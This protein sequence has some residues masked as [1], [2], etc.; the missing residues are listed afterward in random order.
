[1]NELGRNRYIYFKVEEP[2][3]IDSFQIRS[4]Y[5]D[6][7]DFFRGLGIIGYA[8]TFK[9]WLRKFP[10]PIFIVTVNERE[11]ISWAFVEEWGDYARDGTSVYVLR[12]IETLPKLRAK[13]IGFKMMLFILQQITG[14]LITKPLTPLG[15]KFFRNLGFLD[16]TEF[17]NPPVDLSKHP[18][19]LILPPYKRKRLMDDFNKYIGVH[20]RTDKGTS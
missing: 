18:G 14:Y 2:G 17:S 20:A 19:Y 10:R 11:I 13:K 9:M 16:E 5:E 4:E 12:A 1:M 7:F 6:G 3:E 8:K 15:D